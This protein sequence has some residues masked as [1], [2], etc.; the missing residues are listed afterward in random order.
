[1]ALFGSARD[2]SLFRSVNKEIL[3]RVIDTEILYYRLDLAAT[4]TNIYDE[5]DAKVYSQAILLHS[6]I[7]LDNEQWSTEDFGADVTQNGTFAFLRDDLV[8]F[9]AHINVGDIIEYRSRF[10]EIDSVVDNQPVGGKDPDS[11]F[12]GDSHGYNVSVICQAHMT[13]QTKVNIVQTRFGNSVS[14]KDTQLPPNL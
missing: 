3:H 8:D 11:W 7:T 12:G 9:D 5:T 2:A 1:M 4:T 14:I 10:F 13:R 6:L